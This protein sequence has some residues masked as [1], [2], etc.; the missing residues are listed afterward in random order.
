M[1]VSPRV[2][3]LYPP[4]KINLGLHVLGKRPD[5][6]HE[7]RTVLQKLDLRDRVTLTA[8]PRGLRVWCSHP[9]VPDG[10]SNLA[11]RAAE[12]LLDAAGSAAGCSVYIEKRIPV[13]AGLGG[14]SA[15]AASVLFGLNALLGLDR[16][17]GDLAGMAGD[18]GADV[19]FF[20][21]G[22]CGLGEGKGDLLKALKPGAVR[23]VVLVKPPFSVS[24]GWAY[25]VLKSGLT[26]SPVKSKIT[27]EFRVHRFLPPGWDV[28]RNDLEGPVL[29]AH[30]EVGELK[31]RLEDLGADFAL[32]C[33]SGPTVFGWFGDVRRAGRAARILSG[34]GLF[35]RLTRT[36]G[37]GDQMF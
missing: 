18:L 9:D 16:P 33:G 24:T 8:R 5:G 11:Y 3:T 21:G 7:V 28:G 15:D 29:N 20:L 32:M 34:Q 23:A 12:R 37:V 22:P 19:P 35:C 36:L 25:G 26:P 13:A 2:L 10:P 27:E 6:Y 30:P 14:G 4:A 17:A 1:G 31:A